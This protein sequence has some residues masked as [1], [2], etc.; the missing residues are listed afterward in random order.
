MTL[1]L[2]VHQKLVQEPV[3]ILLSNAKQA[4]HARNYFKNNLFQKW[5]IKNLEKS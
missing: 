4:F 5:I 1:K 2:S 3:F